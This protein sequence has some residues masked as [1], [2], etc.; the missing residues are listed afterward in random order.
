MFSLWTKHKEKSG[1]L[2]H[3]STNGLMKM[4]DK[5]FEYYRQHQK[6]LVDKH[7]GKVVV[8]QGEEVI[9]VYDSELEAYNATRKKYEVGTFLVQKVSP[10]SED[11][12]HNYHSRVAFYS[13]TA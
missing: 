1:D 12:S 9:G 7:N 2:S 3:E 13:P 5:E 6:E 11:Y 8:I 10:G 4:L